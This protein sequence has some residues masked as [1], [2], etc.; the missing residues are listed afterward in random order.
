M[1]TTAESRYQPLF[2]PLRL[3]P[4]T[5]PN[6]FYQVPH[7]SG[8]GHTL[9]RTLAGMR[10]MKAEGGWGV[11]CTEYC[12][13]HPSSDDQPY[14]FA[15]LW[16]EGDVANLALMTEQVH[17]HGAL[18]GVELWHG[19]SYVP[20][21]ASRVPPL[22]VRSMPSREEPVQSQ[23]MDRSDVRAFREWHLAAARRARQAGFDIVYVYPTHGY[24]LWEFL[25]RTLNERTDEY[26]GSLENRARL[27]REL[28]E[29]TREA[30]GSSSL[31]LFSPL[32]NSPLNGSAEFSPTFAAR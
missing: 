9:P 6:R 12:S 4:V 15:A 30:V 8:M 5:A 26:G 31:M 24:L 29:E 21:L 25:S 14:P 32:A 11:V 28:L 7:C 16:D 1:G 20:N 2:E 27:L 3:G 13:I 10:A 23:R 17:A 22:G 18:A 19:G